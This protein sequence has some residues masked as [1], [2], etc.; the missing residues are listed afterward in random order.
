MSAKPSQMASD[1]Q[2]KASDVASTAQSKANGAASDLK[3]KAA[4][5]KDTVQSEANKATNGSSSGSTTPSKSSVARLYEVPVVKC[6]PLAC[7]S[8]LIFAVTR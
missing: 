4:E 7:R 6:V 2:D 3:G 8:A 5:A 1:A